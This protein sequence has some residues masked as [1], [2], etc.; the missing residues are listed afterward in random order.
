LL[1]LPLLAHT[2]AAQ[3]PRDFAYGIALVT[4][5]DSAFYQVELPPAVYAGTVRGDLGDVRVFNADGALVPFAMVPRSA[6]GREKRV[7]IYLPQFPLRVEQ[8]ETDLNGLALTLNRTPTGGTTLSLTTRDGAPVAGERLIGYVLDTSALNEP[9][10]ALTANW[11]TL[12]RGVGMRFRIEASDDLANW[13]PVVSDAPSS[14]WSSRGATCAAI[15]SEMPATK[16]KY[17]RLSWAAGQP[18]L[19]LAGMTG[20]FAAR[21]VDPPVQWTEVVGVAVPEHE[22]DYDFDLK[23]AFP[24]ERIAIA[25]PE[26]NTV[27]PAQLSARASPQEPWRVIASNVLYRLRQGD[28]EVN[29]PPVTVMGLHFV[30]GSF[31]SMEARAA[32]APAHHGCVRVGCRNRSCSP[33]AATVPSCSRTAVRRRCPILYRYRRWSPVTTRPPRPRSASPGRKAPTSRRWAVPS[34]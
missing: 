4:E 1:L 15:A 2:A 11:T 19:N 26:Q 7:P 5:G 21:N 23:S 25:L 24:I 8:P 32:W 27:V 22:G 17:L 31:T 13:R 20:E 14:T 34:A 9:L 12:P 18:P 16:A 30:T 29:S 3:A 10:V 28:G 6:P 33:R